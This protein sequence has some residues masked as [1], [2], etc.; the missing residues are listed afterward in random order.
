MLRNEALMALELRFGRPCWLRRDML[1][2]LADINHRCVSL[3]AEQVLAPAPQGPPALRQIGELWRAGRKQEAVEA[4]PDEYLEQTTLLGS[5][6]RIRA[7]WEQGVVGP[8][9]T[10]VIVGAEQPE[11]L[12]LMAELA[13]VEPRQ[14]VNA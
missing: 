14:G 3:L 10:G 9:V 4:V 8:G 13:G 5:P 12:A 6:Q 2:A 11:A 7:R 1:E